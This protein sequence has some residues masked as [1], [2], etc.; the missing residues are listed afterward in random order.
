MSRVTRAASGKKKDV[1]AQESHSQ[2]QIGPNVVT[3]TN[4]NDDV[5][6][7]E[8]VDNAEAISTGG[9]SKTPRRNEEEEEGN[10][11]GDSD[12]TR[13]RQG[14]LDGAAAGGDG[15][16]TQAQGLLTMEEFMRI[17][18]QDRDESTRLIRERDERSDRIIRQLLREN[19]VNHDRISAMEMDLD[20]W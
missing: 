1:R 13:A 12:P 5:L 6:I 17:L 14:N 18:T 7:D 11:S 16:R 8:E 10:I 15:A 3:D 2:E 19:S 9:A 4:A 20:A